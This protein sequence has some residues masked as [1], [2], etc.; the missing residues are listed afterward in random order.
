[1]FKSLVE[2]LDK[3]QKE[4]ESWKSGVHPS[5]VDRQ[6]TSVVEE[7]RLQGAG[8]P[9]LDYYYHYFLSCRICILIKM[10]SN[11]KKGTWRIICCQ[12]C[13]G[14]RHAAA[15]LHAKEVQ[16]A[17]QQPTTS[18]QPVDATNNTKHSNHQGGAKTKTTTTTANTTATT[19]SNTSTIR[20]SLQRLQTTSAKEENCEDYY[21][22]YYYDYKGAD[23]IPQPHN[24]TPH[25]KY[26]NTTTTTTSQIQTKSNYHNPNLPIY[27][28]SSPS[29]AG[30]QPCSRTSY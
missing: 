30:A 16:A 7:R 2:V 26:H 20:Q 15:N 11:V 3:R 19:T 24:T 18:P 25:L 29:C 13:G 12:L 8:G 1:M 28:K 23:H 27:N 22:Y 4:Q 6:H 17:S 14:V 5:P 10:P 21:Y 9:Y